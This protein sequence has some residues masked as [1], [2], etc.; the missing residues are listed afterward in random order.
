MATTTEDARGPMAS[1][2]AGA[3]TG[4]RGTP[5]GGLAMGQLIGSMA[6]YSGTISPEVLELEPGHAR[7]RMADEPPV[8]NHLQSVHA[9]ALMNLG[10]LTTGLALLVGLPPGVRAII[11]HLSMDFLKKARGPIVAECRCELP[12]ARD[13]RELELRAELANAEGVVVARA[14]ARWRVG[15]E[16]TDRHEPGA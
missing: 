15:P 1:A 8:R 6:T 16:P 9:V 12:T 4:L 10:E 7:V 2:L 13:P 5:G 11:T 14:T 3:W